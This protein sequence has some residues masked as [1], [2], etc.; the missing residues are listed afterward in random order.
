LPEDREVLKQKIQLSLQSFDGTIED[1]HAREYIFVLENLE[2]G[3]KIFE[4]NR[5][6][7]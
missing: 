4:N 6:W 1:R 5:N 7:S 2:D 3:R